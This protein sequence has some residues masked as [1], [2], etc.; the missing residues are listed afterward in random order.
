MAHGGERGFG[1]GGGGSGMEGFPLDSFT[2]TFTFYLV[3]WSEFPIVP[4]Y[5]HYPHLI[6]VGTETQTAQGGERGFAGG[7]GVGVV[8]DA[9]V[10][11]IAASRRR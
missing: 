3:P 10:I 4:F 1:G 5:P 7:G 2:P 8:E 9:F 11:S 6:S